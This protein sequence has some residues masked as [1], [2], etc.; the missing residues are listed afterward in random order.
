MKIK[1]L[2]LLPISFAAIVIFALSGCTSLPGD[3]GTSTITGK[4]YTELYN[5][6]GTL[7]QEYYSPDEKVYIIYGDNIAY[8]D[9][10]STA[11][12]GTYKFEYLRKGTY[13]IY[14]Y[15]DCLLC[16]G[17]TEAKIVDVEITDNN[18]VVELADII[19]EK[20]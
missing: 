3:G 17:G 5:A 8:D 1:L 6:S 7:Y 2:A 4:I 11:Y 16:P 13:T 9:E 12:D 18:S 15:S 20:R 10:V 19:I 14:V